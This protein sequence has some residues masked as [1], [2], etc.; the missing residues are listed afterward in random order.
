MNPEDEDE[1]FRQIELRGLKAYAKARDWS[2]SPSLPDPNYIP[3]IGWA[4]DQFA[5]RF[6]PDGLVLFKS[7]IAR[8]HEESHAEDLSNPLEFAA[9]EL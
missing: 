7:S 6:E 1:E 9:L 4:L 5:M 8:Q 3:E 2:L